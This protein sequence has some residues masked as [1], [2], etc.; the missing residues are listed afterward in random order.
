M[1]GFLFDMDGTLLDSMPMWKNL[2]SN[3]LKDFGVDA[4][5][6]KIMRLLERMTIRE[7]ADY[8]HE[9][10]GVDISGEAV[11]GLFL[12]RLEEYYSQEATLKPGAMELLES[13]K[14]KGYPLAVGTA[15]DEHFARMGLETTKIL[16]YFDFV[17]TI[18]NTG[19]HKSE[20]E[21]YNLA[22]M[23]LGTNAEKTYFF[24]D[25]HYALDAAR[26]TGI[27]LVAVYDETGE[28]GFERAR[29]FVDQSV[30]R[31]DEFKL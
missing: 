8:L 24:D 2:E 22:M 29:A 20:K 14:E 13:L 6:P 10:Y 15:T 4:L 3:I 12:R 23:R 21:F 11:E 31:L 7:S 9:N 16:S 1:K 18:N 26:K 25:S 17:Q 30:V 5:D 27:R 28:E 19:I